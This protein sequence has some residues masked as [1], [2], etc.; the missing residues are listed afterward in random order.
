MAFASRR[1]LEA[2][3]LASAVALAAQVAPAAAVP[4]DYLATWSATRGYAVGAVVS[5]GNEVYYAVAANRN[6]APSPTSPQWRLIGRAGM[7]YEGAW[8]KAQTYQAGSVV[9][10]DGQT[11]HSLI[12]N[13]LNKPPGSDARAWVR[14]GTIGN[15]IKSGLGPPL[16]TQGAEGDFWIDTSKY[17]LFGPKTAAGWPPTG[18]PLFGPRGERGAEG[19]QGPKG[20]IGPQGVRGDRGPQGPGG[21][22]GDMGPQGPAGPVSKITVSAKQFDQSYVMWPNF[23]V[24]LPGNGSAL[25]ITTRLTPGR[26]LVTASIQVTFSANRKISCRLRDPD[27]GERLSI[28]AGAQ[29]LTANPLDTEDRQLTM[30]GEVVAAFDRSVALTCQSD[31]MDAAQ[32][33]TPDLVWLPSIIAMKL[34]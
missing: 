20:D 12:A 19:P 8:N 16:A 17:R 6:V 30:T 4:M 24:P 13:N 1:W 18:T 33:G 34:Q 9:S 15:T 27:T 31:L 7:D 3:G 32:A 29:L 25:D 14:I 23:R 22:Q 11:W 2:I 21:L 28:D 26:Y 10:H 5:F